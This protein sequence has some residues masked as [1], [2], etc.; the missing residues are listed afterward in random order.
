MLFTE[1]AQDD[2]AYRSLSRELAPGARLGD[3]LASWQTPDGL[4]GI[5]ALDT[6]GRMIVFLETTGAVPPPVAPREP[7]APVPP[8]P[9]ALPAWPW[10]L[11]LGINERYGHE[12]SGKNAMAW[13][14]PLLGIPEIVYDP[15]VFPFFS[16]GV[17]LF[18][19]AHEY[20][21]HIAGH[22]QQQPWVQQQPWWYQTQFYHQAEFQ[23]DAYA[24]ELLA[25]R[26]PSALDEWAT[27][28]LIWNTP[29]NQTHPSNQDRVSNALLSAAG[30]ASAW[31]AAQATYQAQFAA[32]QVAL[33]HHEAAYDAYLDDLAEYQSALDSY[34]AADV[35]T[36]QFVGRDHL[37]PFGERTPRFVGGMISYTT[38]WGGINVAGLTAGG[39]LEVVWWAPGMPRWSAADLT[40]LTGLAPVASGLMAYVTP[41]GGLNVGGLDDHGSVRVAWWAP[42]QPG[43][44]QAGLT[45]LAQAPPLVGS[46]DT[47]TTEWGALN[48][49]GA[50]QTGDLYVIW[51][52]PGTPWTASNL[53]SLFSGIPDFTGVST[54]AEPGGRTNVIA[55]HDDGIHLF[56]WAPGES[57]WAIAVPPPPMQLRASSMYDVRGA[58]DGGT[59]RSLIGAADRR[60]H[61]LL[62]AHPEAWS[63]LDLS[64]EAAWLPIS[65]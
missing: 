7:D 65:A 27:Q 63:M 30:A 17:Q 61:R 29:A 12:A 11:G 1:H 10:D 38:G 22:P 32:Y 14:H 53:S 58:G 59:Y 45:E 39:G 19:R 15:A 35:W 20:G 40:A 6:S 31:Q 41:W 33:Q 60:L 57:S 56:W 47:Y 42:G 23:A 21:H 50:T 3:S 37:E 51:W 8:S 9:P 44:S 46:L 2:W 48:V 5:A 13:I 55:R 28:M 64:L 34:R 52:T 26:E 62:L 43:W 36:V 25:V 54:F 24:A 18:F 16:P 49:V 4:A